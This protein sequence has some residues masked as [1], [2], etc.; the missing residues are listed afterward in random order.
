MALPNELGDGGSGFHGDAAVR[1]RAILN[2]VATAGADVAALQAAVVA[3]A[4][5]A[6][7]VKADHNA[8]LAKLDLDSGVGDTNYG[9]TLTVAA[10]NVVYTP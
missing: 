1:V 6:N 2:S 10:A 7:E 3:L 9:A 4:T 5:L 8:L